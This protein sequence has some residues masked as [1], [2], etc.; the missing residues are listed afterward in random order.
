L[1]GAN[2]GMGMK[3]E[4]SD[5]MGSMEITM[6]TTKLAEIAQE[7]NLKFVILHGS[8]ATGLARKNSDVDIAVLGNDE[9]LFEQLLKLGGVLEGALGVPGLLD[10]DLKALNKTDPL[11]RYEVIRDGKLLYGDPADYEE[12][13]AVATRAYEDARPL[14]E[15]EHLLARK[16]QKHL[17]KMYVK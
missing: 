12:Y 17:N 10:L 5:I 9:I 16:F 14:L 11:F 3:F 7:F 8:F 4:L 1:G 15:L 13:K 2:N 6:N